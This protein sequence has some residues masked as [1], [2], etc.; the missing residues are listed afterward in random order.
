MFIRMLEINQSLTV[1]LT[2][3]GAEQALAFYQKAFGAEVAACYR[4]PNGYVMH[5]TLKI[6]DSYFYLSEEFPQ[7]QAL[8]PL[9]VG[10]SPNLLCIKTDDPDALHAKAVEAGAEVIDAVQDYIWGERGGVVKDPFGY[11]WAMTKHIEDVSEEEM[12][13][14]VME[15]MGGAAE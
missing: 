1:S 10:G 15:H 7:W 12:N 9:T 14:R 2:V 6:G 8:S 11:R 13:R 4:M 5:A 3:Q